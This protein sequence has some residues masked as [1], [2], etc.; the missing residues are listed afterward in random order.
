MSATT[1][2]AG[3]ATCVGCGLAEG[4]A[5]RRRRVTPRNQP[6]QWSAW[7]RRRGPGPPMCGG[8]VRKIHM[9]RLR[10]DCE[11]SPEQ[12][13]FPSGQLPRTRPDT[14][15]D[16]M[17]EQIH[18]IDYRLWTLHMTAESRSHTAYTGHPYHLL[19]FYAGAVVTTRAAGTGK[20]KYIR[21]P[22]HTM[23]DVT[24]GWPVWIPLIVGLAPGL[25]YWLAITARKSK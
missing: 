5:V 9:S 24:D 17:P 14:T 15:P 10:L 18:V 2:T 12:Q 6:A 23:S 22:A 16:K 21:L 1:G 3:H 13:A 4:Q 25:V 11:H 19:S 20:L 7:P 8:G